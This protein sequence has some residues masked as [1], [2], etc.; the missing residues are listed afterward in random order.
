MKG[1]A[2]PFAKTEVRQM[3]MEEY[4]LR[5]LEMTEPDEMLAFLM[6]RVE[7]YVRNYCGVESLCGPLEVICGNMICALYQASSGEK[8]ISGLKMG[9]VSV[10]FAN[11]EAEIYRQ[12]RLVL[13]LYRKGLFG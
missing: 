6:P 4:I 9:N 11:T 2:F 3:N 10:S 13:N 8:G 7:E 12:Y 1:A 5:R